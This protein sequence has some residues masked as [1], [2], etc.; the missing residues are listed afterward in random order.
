MSNPNL[1]AR[2]VARFV[3]ATALAMPLAAAGA[4]ADEVQIDPQAQQVVD[5]FSKFFAA[6][7]GFR[8]SVDVTVVVES[9]GRKQTRSFK[10]KLAAER[11][12][13]F[14]YALESPE[15]NASVISDGKELSLFISGYDK[16][17]SEKAPATLAE[18]LG[19]NIVVSVM[20]LGNAANVATALVSD[21]PAAKLLT[22][23]TALEYG[24]TVELDGAKCHL[25]RATAEPMDWQI[26]IDAGQQPLVRQFLPDV[27]GAIARMAKARGQES[28]VANIK[29][30]NTVSYTNWEIDP[31]FADDAFA[32]HAPDD[33]KKVAS[34]AE[35]LG[36]PEPAAYSLL[37][38]PAPP[39]D[40]E[41]LD[42]GRLDL[43]SFKGKHVVILD[44]W[45]TWC[46][47]C[48]QAMPIIDKVAKKYEDQ[49]VRL[50]AVNL[51]EDADEVRTFLEE[52]KIEVPVA[53]DTEGT[54]AA[55]YMANAIPQTVLIGKDG[56]VQVVK[57]GL[58]P[59]LEETLSQELEDLVAG[60]N[61]A[62]DLADTK[63]Q[64]D[65]AG[66]DDAGPGE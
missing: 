35:I 17:A 16:Y 42:G 15:I 12:N 66:A 53:L 7:K 14:L 32:F 21:D 47:P 63:Q 24:G 46:G 50:F 39:I 34:F 18:I 58:S 27:A 5:G 28:P 45:A 65:D 9:E 2:R 51:Q 25:L 52:A 19:K 23:V 8:T 26:W 13:E 62:G 56:T 59:N 57:V 43:A 61:L 49:G 30:T 20:Q 55:A 64:A 10:Q 1:L 6:A 11:P 3:V 54:A 38:K 33:A 4:T 22:G 44:F 41:L 60:K 29:V 48:V 40:L 37:G 31:K 36:Q